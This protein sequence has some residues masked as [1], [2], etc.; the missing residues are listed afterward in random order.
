MDLLSVP[1]VLGHWPASL[2]VRSTKEKVF[3]LRVSLGEIRAEI[4]V[5]E[6]IV[7]C[8]LLVPV[9]AELPD[10]SLQASR[11]VDADNAAIDAERLQGRVVLLAPPEGVRQYVAQDAT[12]AQVRAKVQILQQQG[13]QLRE[14]CGR[15]M[16]VHDVVGRLCLCMS[17]ATSSPLPLAAGRRICGFRRSERPQ[18]TV[19][20]VSPCLD[21]GHPLAV[22]KDLVPIYRFIH[23]GG[24]DGEEFDV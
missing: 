12:V 10:V 8:T 5:P 3:W 6:V 13:R 23:M 20:P 9:P 15:C 21:R 2:P 16:R 14:R 7:R 24:G 17:V 18:E 4:V 19:C 1:M 11:A 22:L